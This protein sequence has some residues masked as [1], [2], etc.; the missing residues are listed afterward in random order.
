[1]SNSSSLSIWKT[2]ISDH[3]TNY[4]IGIL[5]VLLTNICQV[6][7][8]RIVGW[9]I[10]FLNSDP[11]PKYFI[12]QNDLDTFYRI[13]WIFVICR[14]LI[15]IGRMGW[16]ITLGRQTHMASAYLRKKIWDNVRY[17]KR[18]DLNTSFTKGHLM[19]ASNSDVNSSRF[20]FGFTIVGFVDVLFL[21]ILTIASMLLISWKMT[22]VSIVVLSILPVLVKKLS[23]SEI[24]KFK[25]SQKKLGEFNDLVSQ[26]ISTV[27]LQRLTQTAHF[28]VK[29]LV[30][31][32]DKYKDVRRDALE[33]SLKYIPVMGGSSVVSYIVLFALGMNLVISNQMS[34]G[35]FVTMQGLIFLLQDPLMEMGFIISDWKKGTTSLE[36]L[37]EIYINEKE[38]HLFNKGE[39][40]KED[41]YVLKVKDLSFSYAE[42]E[43]ELINKLNLSLLPGERFGI[44]G[45][46][47]TGKTTL[48]NLLSGIE[49]N[50]TGKIFFHG[51]DFN[52]YEHN[53]LR[54]YISIVQQRPFLFADT[55]KKNICMDNDL[56]DEDIWYYLELAGLDEDVKNFENKL[57]TAL[58]EWGINLS[59]GQKQRLTLARALARNPKVLFLDDCLS[60]V[61]TVTEEKILQNLDRELSSTTLVWVAHRKSTL[62]YCSKFLHLDRLE[63]DTNE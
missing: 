5:M 62:K 18:G 29:R 38:D 4:I 19:N 32:A 27:K 14:I 36:R 16:R 12:G 8:T 15:T 45:A 43:G 47:G 10:N 31:S 48:L 37:N 33:T 20:I 1:M 28:W 57:D 41:E 7:T 42:S 50:Y 9:V 39:P 40:I 23:A 56:S 63:G 24:I 21:G 17:F 51:R 54:N 2:Y 26:V 13:F 30:D 34:V 11:I 52:S 35:D 44:T 3:K 59:G 61:D 25:R 53:E 22:I 6:L 46:I 49:R 58:G 60:A 55:I